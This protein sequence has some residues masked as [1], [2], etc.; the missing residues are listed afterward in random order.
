[1]KAKREGNDGCLRRMPTTEGGMAVKT[2]KSYGRVRPRDAAGH[3]LRF[4]VV[5]S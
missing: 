1:M 4:R 5:G 2:R 3:G